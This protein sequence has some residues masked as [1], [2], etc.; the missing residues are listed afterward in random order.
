[1]AQKAKA[2]GKARG[3]ADVSTIAWRV[4]EQVG[5]KRL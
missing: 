5:A 4:K 1:M 2:S 3:Y